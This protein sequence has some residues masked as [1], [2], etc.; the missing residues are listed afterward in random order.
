MS[1]LN[2][3]TENIK[4][5]VILNEKIASINDILKH[6]KNNKIILEEAI[7]KEIKDRNLTQAK[8]KINNSHVHYNIAYTMPPISFNIMDTILNNM[9]YKQAIT[10]KTKELILEELDRFRN[11]NKKESITLKKKKIPSPKQNKKKSSKKRTITTVTN[12]V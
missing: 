5:W 11:E 8:L 2:Q 3:L 6:H 9:I 7:L 4:K 10:C 12:K 1:N